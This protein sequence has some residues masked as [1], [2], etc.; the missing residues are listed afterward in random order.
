MPKTAFRDPAGAKLKTKRL[1]VG[2]MGQEVAGKGLN[3]SRNFMGRG[4]K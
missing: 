3:K 1:L 4:E 2:K